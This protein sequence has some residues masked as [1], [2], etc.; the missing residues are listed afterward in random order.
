MVLPPLERTPPPK[1]ES[2]LR[3]RCFKVGPIRDVQRVAPYGRPQCLIH[4]IRTWRQQISKNHTIHHGFPTRARF[5]HF[6]T[7][8]S[9]TFAYTSEWNLAEKWPIPKR[10][11]NVGETWV[12]TWAKRARVWNPW[13]DGVVLGFL[14]TPGPDAR[15]HLMETP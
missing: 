9:P 14:L 3:F 12:E 5:A 15:K 11:R 13:W 1:C 4:R 8:V 6:S 7:H 2:F 10:G